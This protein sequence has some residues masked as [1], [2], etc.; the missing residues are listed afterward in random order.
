MQMNSIDPAPSIHG[1]NT[2]A[3]H[4]IIKLTIFASSSDEQ[5]M[6][7][8]LLIYQYV[9]IFCVVSSLHHVHPNK[10]MHMHLFMYNIA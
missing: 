9:F 6:E 1:L 3:G 10:D 4:S 7:I 8:C 2:P 5:I